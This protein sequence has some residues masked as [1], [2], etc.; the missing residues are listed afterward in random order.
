MGKGHGIKKVSINS[1]KTEK[2]GGRGTGRVRGLE[3]D[4]QRSGGYLNLLY[5]I[6][7]DGE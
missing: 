1:L 6:Y 7:N 4:S 3:W 5:I 2:M